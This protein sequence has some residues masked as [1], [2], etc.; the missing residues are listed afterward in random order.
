MKLSLIVH[1]KFYVRKDEFLRRINWW[2]LK[3]TIKLFRW[4][5]KHIEFYQ[6]TSQ[7]EYATRKRFIK[8]SMIQ[9]TRVF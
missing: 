2:V 8:Q 9:E 6:L 3:E 7:D 1:Q 4:V 5:V